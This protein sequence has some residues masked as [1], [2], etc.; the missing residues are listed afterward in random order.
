MKNQPIRANILRHEA[1]K[2]KENVFNTACVLTVATCHRL[3]FLN[4]YLSHRIMGI[5][6]RVGES[7]I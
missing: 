3:C 6:G 5:E 1:I 4:I 2:M 7:K